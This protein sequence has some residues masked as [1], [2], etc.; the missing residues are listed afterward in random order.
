[1]LDAVTT[2]VAHISS[3]R[4]PSSHT[5]LE[6]ASAGL[7]PLN[8]YASAP[9]KDTLAHVYNMAVLSNDMYPDSNQLRY[10]LMQR[11]K[12]IHE[13]QANR[14]HHEMQQGQQQYNQLFNQQPKTASTQTEPQAPQHTSPSTPSSSAG[15]GESPSAPLHG[16]QATFK[17]KYKALGVD[18]EGIRFFDYQDLTGSKV[19]FVHA[20]VMYAKESCALSG[21][22]QNG[23]AVWIAFR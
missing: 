12:L 2:A 15:S 4:S 14:L 10:T 21:T 5:I 23:P 18:E 11:N 20:V 8:T 17:A 19:Q 16:F 22:K 6:P 7:L 13:Q 1:V 9:N 3:L